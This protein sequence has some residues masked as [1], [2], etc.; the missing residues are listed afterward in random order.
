MSLKF[1]TPLLKAFWKKKLKKS[2][3]WRLTVFKINFLASAVRFMALWWQVGILSQALFHILPAPRALWEHFLGEFNPLCRLTAPKVTLWHVHYHV[4]ALP[5]WDIDVQDSWRR[6]LHLGAAVAGGEGTA[7]RGAAESQQ[8]L[9]SSLPPLHPWHSS[10]LLR[11]CVAKALC[12][13]VVIHTTFQRIP[14]R[15]FV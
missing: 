15:V 14:E 2:G 3:T 9:K 7:R 5:Y 11:F 13:W 1:V 4:C 8:P 6:R 10:V 12:V